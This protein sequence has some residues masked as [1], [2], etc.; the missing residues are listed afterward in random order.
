MLYH[1]I[2]IRLF[3]NPVDRSPPGPSV[4][5]ILQARTLE[6]VTTPSSRG[7]SRP[8]VQTCVSCVSCVGRR[9]LYHQCHQD[10]PKGSILP[11]LTA[12]RGLDI[13][14]PCDCVDMAV[15]K[16]VSPL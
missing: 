16:S 12:L 4:H 15:P 6:W 13:K 8:R 5:G 14:K 11:V 7:S 3:C 2:H 10:A 1:F 9:V